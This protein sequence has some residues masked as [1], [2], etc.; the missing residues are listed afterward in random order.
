LVAR[1]LHL[2]SQTSHEE[3]DRRSSRRQML[4]L[5]YDDLAGQLRAALDQ[6][7]GVTRVE[8]PW[9]AGLIVLYLLL[10]GPG[11]YLLVK[12]LGR[13]HWTWITFPLVVVLFGGLAVILAQRW[14]GDRLHINRVD[15]V[16]LDVES[17]TGRGCTWLHV[18]SP[19]SQSLQLGLRPEW[20]C[21]RAEPPRE[22]LLFSWHGLPGRGLGGLDTP[23]TRPLFS[24][25]YSVRFSPATPDRSCTEIQGL[26]LAV[27]AS[28]SLAAR[29][30][31]TWQAGPPQRL[32]VDSNG[33]LRGEVI[34]PLTSE[35][36][37]ALVFYEN[38]VYEISGKWLPGQRLSLE[39]RSPRNL[40][41]RLTR[42]KVVDS[43]DV[44]TPWDRAAYDVP[45]IV[46]ILMF[47]KAAGGE[48]YTELTNRF[49]PSLDLSDQL[50][51][52]RALIVGRGPGP[53]HDL[54]QHGQPL[55]SAVDRSWTFYRIVIPVEK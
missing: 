11:D 53:A 42:R 25:P 12:K 36:A 46:E 43:K 1:L 41:W 37:D 45:R 4:S 49:T 13:L 7:P 47:H 20:P 39:G 31:T 40:Q 24:A 48:S 44:S 28:K 32:S 55:T 21:P 16:D 17:G 29:W 51:T 38:W 14:R 54:Q 34:N 26:P 5:G 8:F 22:G 2:D 52:G 6:F 27:S 3:S 19:S 33:L 30:W 50:H 10:L 18:Y 35:L 23:A 15:V 9:V